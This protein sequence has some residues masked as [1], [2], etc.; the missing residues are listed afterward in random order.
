M[1]V[2][3]SEVPGFN[4]ERDSILTDKGTPERYCKE[5]CGDGLNYGTLACDDGNN[6]D[7]DGCSSTC[8]VETG[9]SC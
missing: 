9:F 3:C 1:C 7:G 6:D 2:T 5:V 8:E 4:D